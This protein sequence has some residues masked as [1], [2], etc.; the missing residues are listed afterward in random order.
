MEYPPLRLEQICRNVPR[1]IDELTSNLPHKVVAV[2]EM[3]TKNTEGV[4]EIDSEVPK[5]VLCEAK[6]PSGDKK[7]LPDG[8]NHSA[9]A[10]GYAPLFNKL[11]DI[12]RGS[13]GHRTPS[14]SDL[15]YLDKES[16]QNC[17]V[18]PRYMSDFVLA[19]RRCATSKEL[20]WR[21]VYC[22]GVISEGPGI[23]DFHRASDRL[24][25]HAKRCLKDCHDRRFL[26]GLCVSDTKVQ[27]HVFDR[28][29]VLASDIFDMF[30]NP[31]E[32]NRAIIC[33]P[34]LDPV[35]LGKDSTCG[36]ADD[37]TGYICAGGKKYSIVERVHISR[38]LFGPGTYCLKVKDDDE[39]IY[40]LVDRWV[41]RK[42]AMREINMLDMIK[43]VKNVPKL[44]HY[45]FVSIK[46]PDGSLTPDSTAHLRRQFESAQFQLDVF[47]ARDHFRSIVTPCGEPL[48]CFKSLS[49]LI[50]AFIDVLEGTFPCYY[51]L[52]LLFPV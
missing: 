43:D 31:M 39:N 49:E 45:E 7:Q 4:E 38:P 3:L 11:T 37:G 23:S 18:L 52:C 30:K 29:G 19:Q 50:S 5:E 26:L 8:P 28:T 44:T 46:L 20:E 14:D 40:A 13:T 48:H 15:I 35:D 12:I 1:L 32:Y 34:L 24:A 2:V 6:S 17:T 25:E 22:V 21:S 42:D 36:E 16:L 27:M 10:C 41:L 33:L 9:S 47:G 51:L